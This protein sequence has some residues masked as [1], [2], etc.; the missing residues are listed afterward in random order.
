M[1]WADY[2]ARRGDLFTAEYPFLSFGKL[3]PLSIERGIG[4]DSWLPGE[5]IQERALLADDDQLPLLT[6]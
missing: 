4:D 5:D 6:I 3:V 2:L 1:M